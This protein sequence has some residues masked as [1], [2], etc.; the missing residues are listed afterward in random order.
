MG[1]VLPRFEG[2]VDEFV[3]ADGPLVGLKSSRAKVGC[4]GSIV[5]VADCLAEDFP[6]SKAI[7]NSDGQSNSA[8]PDVSPKLGFDSKEDDMLLLDWVNSTGSSKNKDG[9]NALDVVP[10]AK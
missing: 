6:N 3:V 1:G 2:C 10:L 8:K 9:R 5:F 7:P 4:I